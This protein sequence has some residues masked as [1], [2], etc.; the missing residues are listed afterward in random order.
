MIT[1]ELYTPSQ[2]ARLLNVEPITIRR[3]I[4]A[5]WLKAY[6]TPTGRYHIPVSSIEIY[7]KECISRSQ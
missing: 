5:G 7:I 4:Q 6:T 2:A 1:E 3:Y